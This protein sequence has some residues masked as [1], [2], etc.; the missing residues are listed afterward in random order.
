M[1]KFLKDEHRPE[2]DFRAAVN[3]A[4]D[5]WSVG[6]IALGSD[7]VQQVPERS[8]IAQHR[9]EQLATAG[10]EAAVLERNGKSTI[11][12]RTLTD[13]QVRPVISS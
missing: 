3:N 11:R 7:E 13:D 9:Q 6:H 4:L 12:Y 2:A 10:I 8:A 1:E 5:A